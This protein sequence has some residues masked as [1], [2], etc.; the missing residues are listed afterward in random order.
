MSR[1][2]SLQEYE[3]AQDI[4]DKYGL[5]NGWT[6]DSGGLPRFA[7]VNIKPVK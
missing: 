7:G 2:I 6:Q 3:Q 1:R 5:H 4:M